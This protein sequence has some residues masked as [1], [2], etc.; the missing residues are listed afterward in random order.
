VNISS[1][2]WAWPSSTYPLLEAFRR[3]SVFGNNVR[4]NPE[5]ELGKELAKWNKPYRYE[6]YPKMLYK[7]ERR[8]D[9]V[10]KCVE[11]EDRFFNDKPGAAE[12]WST[13]NMK[14]AKSEDEHMKLLGQGWVEGGPLKAVEAFNARYNATA[15]EAAHRAHDDRNMSEKAQ[16]SIKAA[17]ADSFDH[18]PEIPAEPIKRRGRKPGSKNK[19]TLAANAATEA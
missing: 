15:K 7:A 10:V 6:A 2:G 18:V 9:G 19:K 11:T 13:A 16:E 14:E 5:T 12:A 1:G 4:I 3:F 17:E 8:P